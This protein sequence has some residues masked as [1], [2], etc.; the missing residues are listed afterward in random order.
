MYST[1]KIVFHMFTL[2]CIY[3]DWSTDLWALKIN[4][5]RTFVYRR[6]YHTHFSTFRDKCISI[7]VQQPRVLQGC[8]FFLKTKT[9]RSEWVWWLVLFLEVP[10]ITRTYDRLESQPKYVLNSKYAQSTLLVTTCLDFALAKYPRMHFKRNSELEV[11]F[12]KSTVSGV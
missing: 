6:S 4:S 1:C 7:Y 3:V 8:F 5:V 12:W 11:K 10:V 9:H 2:L